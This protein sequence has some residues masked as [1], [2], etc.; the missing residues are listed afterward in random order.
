[1]VCRI[2]QYISQ[3]NPNTLID[4]TLCF[5]FVFTLIV[6]RRVYDF[7]NGIFFSVKKFCLLIF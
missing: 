7:P 6:V 3:S 5:G 1:M 2:D 4:T